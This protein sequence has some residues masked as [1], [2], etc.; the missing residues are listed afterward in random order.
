MNMFFPLIVTL[1]S[2]QDQM[3]KL[4]RNNLI[5]EYNEDRP[6]FFRCTSI[7]NIIKIADKVGF[8][9]FLSYTSYA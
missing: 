2:S 9:T 4:L 1:F 5:A 3:N 7:K 6:N 8:D